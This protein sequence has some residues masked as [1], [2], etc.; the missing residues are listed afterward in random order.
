MTE[1]TLL[2]SS[3]SHLDHGAAPSDTRSVP[4]ALCYVRVSTAEQAD[5]AH[6]LPTQKRKVEDRC[7]RDGLPILRTFGDA[8][9]SARTSDRPQF[10]AMLE[11]CRTHKAKVT[12]VVF[13]D[14]SRLA[15]N[16]QDQ[17]STLAQFEKLGIV[18][19]SCDERIEDSA[20]GKLSVNILGVLNQFFSDSLSERTRYRMDVGAKE[21]RHLHLAPIGY[22]NGA[23]GSGLQVDTERAALVRQA[24]EW[25]ATRSYSLEEILRRL[26]LLGLTTKRANRPINRQTQSRMLRNPIY[27]GWVVSRDTKARGLH[28]PIVKQELFD[29]VQDALDGKDAA[30]IV[31]KKMNEDFPPRGFVLCTGCGKKLTAGWVKGRKEKYPKYWCANKQCVARV[32]ASRDEIENA[33]LRIIGMLVPTQ[34]FLNDLPRI[35][36]N[37]WAQRLERLNS[38]RR[39]LNTALADARCLNQRILLK[40]LNGDMSA[41]DFAMLKETVTQQKTNAETQLAALDAETSAMQSLMEGTQREIV[42]LVGMWQRGGVQQRQELAFSLYPDG[43]YFSR[44]TR[45]FEPRNVLLQ[46]AMQEMITYLREEKKIGVGDGN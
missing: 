32:S 44:E 29:A 31:H 16:I 25:V 40:N 38:E 46:N 13:A 10:Q 30:P 20:A 35:A 18:P 11:Y 39:R 28:E 43:L 24:F 42:N 14:L 23:N 2:P 15:R 1:V 33:F 22:I 34:A 21:G 12:H 8:G 37:R 41:E 45:F 27:A 6:N 36:K 26:K 3:K 17:A 19:V 4:G 7:K 5:Q 9:E